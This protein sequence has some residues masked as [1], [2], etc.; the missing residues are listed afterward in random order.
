MSRSQDAEMPARADETE[1]PV[2]N[3]S[4]AL[5]S[6]FQFW[7]FRPH[8]TPKPWGPHWAPERGGGGGGGR[9]AKG[10]SHAPGSPSAWTILLLTVYM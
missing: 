3:K 9:L 7:V 5:A 1:E 10:A 6:G 8:V 2:R 4:I